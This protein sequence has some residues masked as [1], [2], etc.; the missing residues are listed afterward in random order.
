MNARF[1]RKSRALMS[2]RSSAPFRTLRGARR[3]E[4]A[5]AGGGC[6]TPWWEARKALTEVLSFSI[7]CSTSSTSESAS[8]MSSS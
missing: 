3:A 2:P 5:G 6:G 7:S 8:P 4:G 1:A